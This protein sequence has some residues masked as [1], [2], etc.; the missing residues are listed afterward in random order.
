MPKIRVLQSPL[1]RIPLRS[2]AP[3]R[4]ATAHGRA[5]GGGQSSDHRYQNRSNQDPLLL[6]QGR[7]EFLFLQPRLLHNRDQCA[8]CQ[9]WMIR[10]CNDQISFFIPEV[11]MATYLPIDL[12]AKRIQGLDN[13]F[14]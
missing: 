14:S 8:L 6:L 3:S 11:D 10:N 1:C 5:P 4:G 9:L 13:L 12:E 2:A 7:N